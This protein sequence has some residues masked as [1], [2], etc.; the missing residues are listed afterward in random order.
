VHTQNAKLR[1]GVQV[2]AVVA[3]TQNAGG[4][5]VNAQEQNALISCILAELENELQRT[6][7]HRFQLPAGSRIDSFFCGKCVGLSSAITAVCK[8]LP[9]GMLCTIQEVSK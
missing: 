7:E 1:F 5:K 3:Q 2:C 6:R 8:R 4:V 9:Y